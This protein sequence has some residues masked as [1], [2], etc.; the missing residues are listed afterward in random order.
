MR[1]WNPCSPTG[2]AP[3]VLVLMVRE[4]PF[5]DGS[6]TTLIDANN[7]TALILQNA[8]SPAYLLLCGMGLDWH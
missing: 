1:M 4:V 8:A 7:W 2:L 5:G 6:T 3:H